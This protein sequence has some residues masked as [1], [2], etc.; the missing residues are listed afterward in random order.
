MV[1]SAHCVDRT[2][3]C[4]LRRA[5][6]ATSEASLFT[7]RF[8]VKSNYTF[9]A[10]LLIRNENTVEMW[11]NNTFLILEFHAHGKAVM[12]QYK[13]HVNKHTRWSYVVVLVFLHFFIYNLSFVHVCATVAF[14]T[15]STVKLYSSSLFQ[16]NHYIALV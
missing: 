11:W 13:I 15:G 16:K 8:N 3:M 9:S 10:F 5:Q 14:V 4:V 6:R 1:L 2:H 7:L 12:V